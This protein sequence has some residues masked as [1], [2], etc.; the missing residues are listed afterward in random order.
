MNKILPF[1]N[2]YK[3]AELKA[4]LQA[5]SAS[6]GTADHVTSQNIYLN[7]LQCIT[8]GL[9]REGV[10]SWG[11]EIKFLDTNGTSTKETNSS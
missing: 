11:L 9:C 5:C 4:M 1:N 6:L 10:A 8:I 2:V 7:E 3:T